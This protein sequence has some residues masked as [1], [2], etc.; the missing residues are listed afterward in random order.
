MK[1]LPDEGAAAHIFQL[2]IVSIVPTL[3]LF[4]ATTD[5]TQPVRSIR[6][7]RVPTAALAL[8]FGALY[9]LEHV[10]YR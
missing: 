8:A 2:L 10:F 5:W 1:P 7:L 4:L 3:T 9:Y 6:A